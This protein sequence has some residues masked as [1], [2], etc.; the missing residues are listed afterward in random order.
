MTEVNTAKD[1]SSCPFERDAVEYRATHLLRPLQ[2]IAREVVCEGAN[3]RSWFYLFAGVRIELFKHFW[4]TLEY[5]HFI[6]FATRNK[7]SGREYHCLINCRF[8]VSRIKRNPVVHLPSPLLVESDWKSRVNLETKAAPRVCPHQMELV[9]LQG[10][11]FLWMSVSFFLR[12][13]VL[14]FSAVPL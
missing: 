4:K 3:F 9:P 12:C 10:W 5:H 11:L 1:S 2:I 8:F 13:W 7:R 14:V 6:C